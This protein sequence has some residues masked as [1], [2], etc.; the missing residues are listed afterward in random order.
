[1]FF[2]KVS[3]QDIFLLSVSACSQCCTVLS[4]DHENMEAHR[5]GQNP[6]EDCCAEIRAATV[7][8]PQ[9]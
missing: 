4:H 1:M 5:V 6:A 3:L 8:T 7:E 2:C 9:P